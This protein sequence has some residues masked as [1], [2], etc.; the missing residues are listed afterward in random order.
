MSSMTQIGPLHRPTMALMRGTAGA[1]RMR[2]DLPNNR[3]LGKLPIYRL[4]HE[5]WIWGR[6]KEGRAG[7]EA[8]GMR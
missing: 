5:N 6:G 2:E 8:A 4:G 3:Y 7:E 1:A